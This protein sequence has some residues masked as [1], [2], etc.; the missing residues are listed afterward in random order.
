MERSL[1]P[2]VMTAVMLVLMSTCATADDQGDSQSKRNAA[3]SAG[4]TTKSKIN[5]A[6]TAYSTELKRIDAQINK[7]KN[8]FG[9]YTLQ[10]V[11]AMREKWGAA[12]EKL[13]A[14]N[15]QTLDARRHL[16]DAATHMT[17][18]NA[19]HKLKQYNDVG[20]IRGS[21]WRFDQAKSEYNLG[22]ADA[23]SGAAEIGTAKTGNRNVRCRTLNA[24][25]HERTD[26]S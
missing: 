5:L 2:I 7:L 18:G 9:N 8:N 15:N 13:K 22:Q 3:E 12:A 6:S 1:A 4:R 17:L 14:G 23:V 10:E 21:K 19:I 20:A 16:R 11:S 26:G 24:R 25:I